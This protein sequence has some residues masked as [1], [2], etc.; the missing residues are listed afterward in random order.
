MLSYN[1]HGKTSL[2]QQIT[3]IKPSILSYGHGVKTAVTRNCTSVIT[4]PPPPPPPPPQRQWVSVGNTWIAI[5][6]PSK[7]LGFYL[8]IHAGN[9]LLKF[10]FEIQSQIK[11]KSL[12]AQKS[13][14]ATTPTRQPFWK[15]HL[16]KFLSI[17]SSNM[18]LKFGL[19]IQSQ[20]EVRVR[21]SKNPRWPPGGHFESDIA[22]SHKASAHGHKQYLY[23]IWNWNSKANLSY[24][25]ETTSP[26]D[27]WTD[28]QT[29]RRTR[30]IQCT[31]HQLRWVGV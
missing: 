9:V 25:L 20:N 21:K 3:K 6:H 4:P 7:S 28:G 23:Q 29:D 11:V 26:T 19:D 1:L 8:P 30:L 14:V 13:N 2:K 5:E 17:H 18:I 24:A 10:G 15:W 22:E 31:P 12:E 27:G 16:W